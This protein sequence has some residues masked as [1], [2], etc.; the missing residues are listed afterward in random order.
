MIEAIIFDFDGT[1]VDS[2]E[3]LLGFYEELFDAFAAPQPA[4]RT[5]TVEKTVQGRSVPELLECFVADE[6]LRERMWEH[7]CGLDYVG[8]TV[9]FQ[10]EPFVLECLADLR[11]EY[12][13]ALATNRTHEMREIVR[14]F[15]L[16]DY[17]DAVLTANQ[18]EK[19]KPSPD[20]LFEA[21]ARLEKHP[22]HVLYIGDTALDQEAA[23]RAGMP[24][25]L[26]DRL[27][28]A[29]LHGLDHSPQLTDF[30]RLRPML[31]ALG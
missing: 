6:A 27:R 20:L 26:Y 17:L 7:V 25:L 12:P 3:S 22:S 8:L 14:H 4:W 29:E 15:K 24:F 18:V 21:A 5:P 11:P 9:G 30:R 28:Q 10:L 2:R 31:K 13:L 1:L 16:D 19:P 23:E